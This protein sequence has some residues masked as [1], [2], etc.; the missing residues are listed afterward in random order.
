MNAAPTDSWM[1]GLD[2]CIQRRR[3]RIISLGADWMPGSRPGMTGGSGPRPERLKVPFG[4][5]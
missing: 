5:P 2:P 4:V 3:P 1:H